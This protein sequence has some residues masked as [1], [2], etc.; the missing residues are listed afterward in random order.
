MGGEFAN[1]AYAPLADFDYSPYVSA[2]QAGSSPG[3][4][5]G[6]DPTL[7]LTE[8]AGPTIEGTAHDNLAI[9]AVR[10]QDDR[11]RSGVARMNWE[12]LEGDYDSGYEWQTRWSFAAADVSPA[13]TR[14]EVVAED[15]KGNESAP[16]GPRFERRLRGLGRRSP[17]SPTRRLPIPRSPG[18]P[19]SG[20][21]KRRV[22]LRA[23]VERG[24]KLVRVQDRQQ[25]LAALRC[26]GQ[27]LSALAR[28]A[29][30]SVSLR[31]IAAGTPIRPRL[32]T[33]LESSSGR[34]RRTAIRRTFSRA[35]GAWWRRVAGSATCGVVGI[36]RLK[37]IAAAGALLG[38]AALA[39]WLLAPSG[40]DESGSATSTDLPN[41]AGEAGDAADRLIFWRACEDVAALTDPELDDLEGTRRGRLRLHDRAPARPGRR[42]DFSGDPDASL[43][44][45]QLRA[46]ALA[47][48][49]ADRRAGEGAR[50]EALPRRQARQLL[51]RRDPA[52]GLVR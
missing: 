4:V 47:A 7:E 29:I 30:S 46:A 22:T 12:V 35:T 26:L 32:C 45:R 51:Q 8:T 23:T 14:V 10:W 16:R 39:V 40:A 18:S 1:Y 44:G 24:W 38:L 5:D 15:I 31:S 20:A 17:R 3:T 6:V 13:A 19:A 49:L 43:D 2:M 52:Q 33:R 27:A 9:R 28:G 21:S 48:R 34:A 25:A 37:Y 36:D 50:N 42:Q 41:P 11:G